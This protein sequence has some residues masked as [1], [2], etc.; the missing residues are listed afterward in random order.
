MN[1]IRVFLV[2]DHYVACYGLRLMLE[3]EEDLCVVGEAQSGEE[4][5]AKLQQT[6]ADVVLMDV[7]LPGMDGIETLQKLKASQPNVKVIMLTSFGGDYL[8][9]ALEAG[10]TGY[11]IKRAN[12]IEIAKAI[13][14]AAQGGAPLDA[15]ATAGL[16][17]QFRNP[18]QDRRVP[19]TSRQAQVLELAAAGLSNKRIAGMLNISETTIKNHVTSIL[20]NLDANDRTHAVTISLRKGWISNPVADWPDPEPN[21][22]CV[23]TGAVRR[24]GLPAFSE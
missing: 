15:L 22:H 2:D 24:N 4:A 7:Q 23:S 5:L 21:G 14:E 10:A 20:R 3:Q 16:V 18:H 11:L 13:H 8:I 17:D 19:I 12:R 9:P 6:P 1:K